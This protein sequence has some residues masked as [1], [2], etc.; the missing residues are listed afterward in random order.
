M[1]VIVEESNSMPTTL[2]VCSICAA[3]ETEKAPGVTLIQMTHLLEQNLQPD[4]LPHMERKILQ[5]DSSLAHATM[6]VPES[7]PEP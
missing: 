5:E 2:T 4:Q 3:Q 6:T 1:G 7:D